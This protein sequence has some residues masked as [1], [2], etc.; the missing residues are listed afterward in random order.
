MK[1]Y[2]KFNNEMFTVQ[3]KEIIGKETVSHA[4]EDKIKNEIPCKNKK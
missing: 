4:D 1:N 2:V 3:K